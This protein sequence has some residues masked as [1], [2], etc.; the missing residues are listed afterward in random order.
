MPSEL[1]LQAYH[2]NQIFARY[3]C[4]VYYISWNHKT[5]EWVAR[6]NSLKKMWKYYLIP[7]TNICGFVIYVTSYLVLQM[8]PT[9]NTIQRT[10]TQLIY[11]GFLISVIFLILLT[12]DL[13]INHQESWVYVTNW[14][15]RCEGI[16][17]SGNPR[18]IWRCSLI[19]AVTQTIKTCL[20]G[21][22]T[23]AVIM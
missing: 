6:D 21:M 12:D 22:Q 15:L 16:H 4:P 3:L 5:L 23:F 17:S 10:W 20:R 2:L 18:E 13:F 1:M 14:I 19:G 8:F 7:F 11:C 9:T